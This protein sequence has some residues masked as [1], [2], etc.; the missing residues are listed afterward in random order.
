MNQSKFPSNRDEQC[1]QDVVAHYESQSDDEAVAE[2]KHDMTDE[3]AIKLM[4]TIADVMKPPFQVLELALKG[5]CSFS[6][7]HY[8]REVISEDDPPIKLD[9]R[10]DVI[11][12]D[13]FL[14]LYSP[15]K[16]KITIFN[17]G[18]Q[19]ASDVL[20]VNPRHLKIIVRIHEWAHAL[21]HLGVAEIDRQNILKDD[22]YWFGILDAST[23]LFKEI[24]HDL[25]ELIA[26][27]LTLYCIQDN[28]DGSTTNQGKQ[29]WEEI[30][31]AFHQLSH[32]QPQEYQIHD[33]IDLPRERFSKSVDLLRNRW[34]VGKAEPWKTAIKW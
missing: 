5:T 22:S 27:M 24:E 18:I 31:R 28:R 8:P 13:G 34:L 7:G 12:I 17:K 20:Q 15:E 16:Q 23:K 6:I 26:Q 10:V 14:G 29:V 1:V 4:D 33:L 32:H 19:G 21:L 11:P 2:D 3:E 9:R 30:E 25:H